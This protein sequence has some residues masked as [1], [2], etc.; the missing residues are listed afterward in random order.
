MV[1]I[2]PEMHT[3]GSINP[4]T[5]FVDLN[6]ASRSEIV[7]ARGGAGA[8]QGWEIYEHEARHWLDLVSTVWG[9]GYLDLDL[10]FRTY[11]A[12]LTTPERQMDRTV[13]TVLELFDRDRSILFPSYYKYVLPEARG[14][15]PDDRWSMGFSTGITVGTDGQLDDRRPFI[16]VRFDAGSTHFA[17]QPVS[18]GSL[19]ETRALAA[20]VAATTEWLR[21]R[22]VGED[23][24]TWQ[25]REPEQRA[26]FYNPELT[27]YSV[28][29]HVVA[30]ATGVNQIRQNLALSSKLADIVLNLTD[31][32]FAGLRPPTG[33]GNPTQSRLRGFRKSRSRGFAFCCLAFGLRPVAGFGDLGRK[34]IEVAMKMAGLPTLSKVYRDARQAI[35]REPGRC[36]VQPKLAE[37]RGKLI[38]AG[39]RLHREPDFD[40]QVAELCPSGDLPAP[41]VGDSACE[42]FSLGAAPLDMAE[43]EFLFDC[44]ERYREVLRSALRAARGFEFVLTDFVY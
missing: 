1:E 34:E 15:K 18:D 43:S 4:H 37:I 12:I 11:D 30:Y 29:A 38:D 7:A 27:T 21:Q 24:V 26:A 20:E 31:C 25:L 32:C 16:F 23:V 36:A 5:L 40:A 44:H 22:P 13:Q 8:P 28:A 6:R 39:R 9:R 17:R 19:L 42:E 3:L 10:L 41:L 35:A 14:L 33:L 2:I